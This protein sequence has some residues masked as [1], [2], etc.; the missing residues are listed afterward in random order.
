[1]VNDQLRLGPPLF[2]RLARR[3]AALL[4]RRG[5]RLGRLQI[6]PGMLDLTRDQIGAGYGHPTEAAT[7]AAVLAAEE[8]LTL[9]PVYTAKAMAGLLA[10][11]GQGRL[12]GPVLFVHTDGPR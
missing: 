12:G 11:R 8:R 9:D 2:A 4:E 5:A 3:T 6:E 10:L 7:R 1:V